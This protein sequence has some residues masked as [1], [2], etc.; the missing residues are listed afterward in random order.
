M[1]H[2][3]TDAIAVVMLEKQ[4]FDPTLESLSFDKIGENISPDGLQS[5]AARLSDWAGWDT[6]AIAISKLTHAHQSAR[7]NVISQGLRG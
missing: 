6:L 4:S 5:D 3:E 2:A 1:A 7:N